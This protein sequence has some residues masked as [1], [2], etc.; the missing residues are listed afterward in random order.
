MI[1]Q[2]IDY[3]A[4]KLLMKNKIKIKET[5]KKKKVIITVEYNEALSAVWNRYI[6][7]Q[8]LKEI[9]S[10]SVHFLKLISFNCGGKINYFMISPE[11]EQPFFLAELLMINKVNLEIT[12]SLFG[13]GFKWQVIFSF[14]N[15]VTTVVNEFLFQNIEEMDQV[16]DTKF[17]EVI[18]KI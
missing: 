1:L 16:N 11:M 14:R 7:L 8:F 17:F 6:D 13:L 4:N 18:S 5:A 2:Q 3:L 12:D 10:N 15:N 9:N